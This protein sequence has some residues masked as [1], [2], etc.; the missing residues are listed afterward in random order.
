[1]SY[2]NNCANCEKL[3]STTKALDR[4]KGKQHS[5]KYSLQFTSMNNCLPNLIAQLKVSKMKVLRFISTATIL[6]IGHHLVCGIW[7]EK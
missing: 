2:G 3:F 4:H 6:S 5:Q 1:M 7:S